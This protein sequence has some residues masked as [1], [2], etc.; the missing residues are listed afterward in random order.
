MIQIRISKPTKFRSKHI[1]GMKKKKNLGKDSLVHLIHHDL[2][3]LHGSLIL[4]RT[5]EIECTLI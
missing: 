5:I 1:K 3:D 4:I 2:S